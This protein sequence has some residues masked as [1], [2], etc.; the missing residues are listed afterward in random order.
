VTFDTPLSDTTSRGENPISFEIELRRD[1]SAQVRYG[2]GNTNVFPVVGISGGEPDAYSVASHTSENALINLTNA[3]TVTFSPRAAANST[4]QFSASG[5]SVNEGA[6]HVTMT[7]VRTGDLSQAASVG[8]QTV[9]DP[10]PVPC[11][12]QVN[13]HGAAYARC[14]YVTTVGTM[15]FAAGET[16]HSFNIPIINDGM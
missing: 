2:A 7:V 11:S 3:A 9:D 15:N 1:G 14:D 12:D 4:V 5:A 8:Y 13:N 10:A 6:G 16:T